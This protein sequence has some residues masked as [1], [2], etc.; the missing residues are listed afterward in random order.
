MALEF[1]IYASHPFGFDEAMLGGL[2][3]GLISALRAGQT[4]NLVV[5]MICVL[6]L[7][8]GGGLF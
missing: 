7:I 3:I 4:L 5:I 1:L 6:R 2:L 8:L